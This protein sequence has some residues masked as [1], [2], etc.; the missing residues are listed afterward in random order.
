[1]L[2]NRTCEFDEILNLIIMSQ[3]KCTNIRCRRFDRLHDDI[4]HV[5][6]ELITH[7]CGDGNIISIET[8][9][10]R[11][12]FITKSA[13]FTF[14]EG[15]IKLFKVCLQHINTAILVEFII[16]L[17]HLKCRDA[18][19]Y[20]SRHAANDIFDFVLIHSDCGFHVC[21]PFWV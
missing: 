13:A 21:F 12:M 18:A 3:N 17:Q 19:L 20:H 2:L 5:N 4:H 16:D 14:F 7:K 9:L 15:L 10:N 11:E 8:N 1:M 6:N